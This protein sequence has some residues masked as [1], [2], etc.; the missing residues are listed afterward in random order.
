MSDEPMRSIMT[1]PHFV[2]LVSVVSVPWH[3]PSWRRRHPEVNI[4]SHVDDLMYL[5]TEGVFAQPE[6][7]QE[8]RSRFISLLA[9]LVATDERL[10]YSA[11][12]LA[13]FD[14][15]MNSSRALTILLVMMTTI[16]SRRVYIS[17]PQLEAWGLGTAEEWR[18]KADS[19]PGAFF[20]RGDWL[21]PASGLR[22]IGVPVRNF[23]AGEITDPDA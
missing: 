4:Q 18:K 17:P 8:F 14:G 12:D 10:S 19:V 1:N 20:T 9:L 5:L 7:R 23:P 21:F 13:W 3:S 6:Y 16:L 15:V 11:E 22:A 2:Q